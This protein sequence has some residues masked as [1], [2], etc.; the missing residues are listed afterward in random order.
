MK[1]LSNLPKCSLSIVHGRNIIRS[2]P[3]GVWDIEFAMQNK[4]NI[5]ELSKKF[6][7]MPWVFLALVYSMSPI[8]DTETSKVFTSFYEDFPP[9]GCNTFTFVQGREIL[10]QAHV[11]NNEPKYDSNTNSYYFRSEGEALDWIYENK[12][13]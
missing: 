4:K 8:I 10:I 12:N 11:K 6:N 3:E 1:K 9:L 13:I 2:H 7:G 5:M